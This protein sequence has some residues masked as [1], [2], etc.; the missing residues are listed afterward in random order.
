MFAQT[1]KLELAESGVASPIGGNTIELDHLVTPLEPMRPIIVSGKRR[2]RVVVNA[3]ALDF[4]SDDGSPPSQ[5]KKEDV[6]E[7]IDPPVTEPDGTVRWRLLDKNGKAG[8]VK[9]KPDNI[10]LQSASDEDETS[11]ELAF[12]KEMSP[13]ADQTQTMLVL[14]E[15]QEKLIALLP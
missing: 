8:F 5:L 3:A 13:S 9:T 10:V 15:P 2:Q 4:F 12:I 1:E 7:V 14:K 6:L 11:S